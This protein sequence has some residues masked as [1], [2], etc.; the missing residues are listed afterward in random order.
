MTATWPLIAAIGL[1][2]I[3][4][5]C[6]RGAEEV[7]VVKL[8]GII[9]YVPEPD[10]GRRLGS[11]DVGPI[12]EYINSAVAAAGKVVEQRPPAPSAKGLHLTIGF[13]PGKKS[14]AWCAA[15]EGEANAELLRAI[16]T[17]VAKLPAIDVKEP[18]AFGV[19]LNVGGQQPREF[20]KIPKAWLE[21]LQKSGKKDIVI[22]PPDEIFKLVWPEEP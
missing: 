17:E 7:K 12:A 13:K 15:V 16:E 22:A 5:S 19:N 4:V 11:N 14:K 3:I 9:L 2:S 8:N 1:L 18:F 21:A 20:P 6:V 10:V